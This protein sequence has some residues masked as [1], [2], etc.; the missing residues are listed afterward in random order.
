MSKPWMH[1]DTTPN[2]QN[3][4]RAPPSNMTGKGKIKNHTFSGE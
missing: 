4:T 3:A 1:S 2:H